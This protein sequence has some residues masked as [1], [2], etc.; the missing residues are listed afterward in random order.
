MARPRKG[1]YHNCINCNKEIYDKPSVNRLYCSYKCR[2]VHL[3]TW[4]K[5]KTDIYSEE[6]KRKMAWTKGKTLSI[7][8]RK[9]ISKAHKIR[10]SEGKNNFWKGGILKENTKIRS[11]LEYKLWRTS[12]FERDN[13]TCQHCKRRNGN[14]VTITLNADH[15]KP[16]AYH[17]EL[18]LDINNGRTLC[19]DCHKKTDTYLVHRGKQ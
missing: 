4:N 16:F 9:N 19:V 8:H 13:Y 7:E 10:V 1:H 2:G 12:V 5:G 3:G 11:S 17:K 14:G 18:R 6:T 15:I